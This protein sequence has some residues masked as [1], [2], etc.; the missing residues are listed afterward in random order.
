M[1]KVNLMCAE[2][3]GQTRNYKKQKSKKTVRDATWYD[4]L[5]QLDMK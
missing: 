5:F 1:T 4:Q 2:N 3:W